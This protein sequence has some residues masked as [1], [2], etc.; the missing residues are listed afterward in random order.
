[1]AKKKPIV[2]K[3]GQWKY[4]GRDTIIPTNNGRITMKPDPKTGKPLTQPI[5]GID[6]TGFGQMMFPG[7]DYQFPGNTIYETPMAKFQNGGAMKRVKI[8]SL[9]KAQYGRGSGG[10]GG[11][12]GPASFQDSLDVANSA[13]QVIDWYNSQGYY[14]GSKVGD[15]EP[16]RSRNGVRMIGMDKI[17]KAADKSTTPTTLHVGGRQTII[18]SDDLGQ[19]GLAIDLPK[20]DVEIPSLSLGEAG[21]MALAGGLN[22]IGGVQ[23]LTNESLAEWE[24]AYRFRQ[25]ADDHKKILN[26]DAPKALYDIRID[27]RSTFSLQGTAPGYFSGNADIVDMPIY[28]KFYT[29]PWSILSPE[30][31]R[32]RLE[33]GILDGTP[34][35]DW[36]DPRLIQ[37]YPDIAMAHGGRRAEGYDKQTISNAA[38]SGYAATQEGAALYEKNKWGKNPMV[39]DAQTIA[40]AAKSGYPATQSGAAEY[41]QNKWAKKPK[42]RSNS[43]SGNGVYEAIN[44]VKKEPNANTDIGYYMRT[45]LGL[46]KKQSSYSERKKLA[47]K[48][49]IKD[50]SGTGKQN[51]ELLNKIKSESNPRETVINLLSGKTTDVIS[52]TGTSSGATT[53]TSNSK[54]QVGQEDNKSNTGKKSEQTVQSG[55]RENYS[56]HETGNGG[57]AAY[58][59]RT[60][61]DENGEVVHG[62]S[63]NMGVVLT[64]DYLTPDQQKEF[65]SIAGG[66]ARVDFNPNARMWHDLRQPLDIIEE[67]RGTRKKALEMQKRN[68]DEVNAEKAAYE[69]YQQQQRDQEKARQKKIQEEIEAEKKAGGYAYGGAVDPERPWKDKYKSQDGNYLYKSVGTNGMQD[70]ANS[71]VRRTLKGF[72]TGAPKPTKASDTKYIP[73]KFQDGGN[74]PITTKTGEPFFDWDKYRK[75]TNF[76]K[77]QLPLEEQDAYFRNYKLNE[78]SFDYL[79]DHLDDPDSSAFAMDKIPSMSQV[80]AELGPSPDI[81]YSY[82]G[83]VPYLGRY[84]PYGLY[85]GLGFTGDLPEARIPSGVRHSQNYIDWNSYDPELRYDYFQNRDK[86]NDFYRD[87]YTKRAALPQFTE[88]ANRRLAGLP[89]VD[90]QP[91]GSQE[92]YDKDHPGSG[93]V[94]VHS[95]A[96]NVLPVRNSIYIPP[97]GFKNPS[98]MAHEESHYLDFNHPQNPAGML[99][100][101]YNEQDAVL[102]SI[103]PQEYK[104]PSPEG[105]D[106]VYK[107]SS[108]YL[109]FA[110]TE[111]MEPTNTLGSLF[112]QRKKLTDYYYNPSEI[113]ARLNEWRMQHN[114]DPVKDYTNEEIQRIIDADV[115]NNEGTSFDLYKLIRG[116]GDLLKKIHDSQVSTGNKKD[117]Y[118]IPMGKKGGELPKAQY[119][120]PDWRNILDYKNAA[121]PVKQNLVGDVRKVARPTAVAESTNRNVTHQIPTNTKELKAEADAQAAYDAL[122]EAMKRRDTLTADTRSD[123]EKFARQAWTAISY[124][125]ATISAVNRGHDIPMGSLGMYSPYEGYDVGGPMNFLVDAVA[126]T[127]GFIV[128]AASR[129]GEQLVDDPLKYAYTMSPLGMLDPETQGQALS[130]TLDLSAVI[131]AARMTVGPLVKNTNNFLNAQPFL[132]DIWKNNPW[133]FQKNPEAYYH[134][135]PNPANIINTEKGVLQG[136][137]QS[138]EGMAYNELAIPGKGPGFVTDKGVQTGLNLRKAAHSENYFSKGVPLDWG[139]YN[140]GGSGYAGPYIAEVTGVPFVAKANGKFTKILDPVT[141]KW[142][143]GVYP[144]SFEG[145]YAVPKGPVPLGNTK[146]YKE[147]WLWGYKQIGTPKSLPNKHLPLIGSGLNNFTEQKKQGGEVKRVK[148]NALPNNWKS[149]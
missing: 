59:Y 105:N 3:E 141:G 33:Y 103:I 61:Y 129:Q 35:K 132:K 118:A 21:A 92:E 80:D 117:P 123:A 91:Y 98:V 27:P 46:D 112:G 119:G 31:K 37:N 9:P 22:L 29:A 13:Q 101:A 114:I 48:Y 71:S 66:T 147:D 88:V 82:D 116:R 49:G 87:W 74:S 53:S 126:G 39:Y 55:A 136:F 106:A 149:Q 43:T 75:L 1:M 122:P 42:T 45:E 50:Y 52:N 19:S 72:I 68:V 134:R 24:N 12:G 83:E 121:P 2:S 28:E 144:P 69:Q 115:K 47:E 128:N 62:K 124:P 104:Q 93:G 78:K 70:Y 60:V 84:N 25:Y 125:M 57:G 63:G 100:P 20:F 5:Y 109:P 58:L 65:D 23:N 142:T 11:P 34:F 32:K 56:L 130:N 148:I 40:N 143:R 139:R 85:P 108:V 140:P 79:F 120:P 97:N 38:K 73:V 127:P 137:G 86:V 7:I 102:D 95:P 107:S 8:H 4:P 135:T 81:Q 76:Q 18:G 110:N 14:G 41:D 133:R 90:F 96:V 113:R 17:K 145:G 146:F 89:N 77:D 10:P 6:E 26:T 99:S 51:I 64:E 94:Y 54:E 67:Q 15:K 131:P 138:P 36:N 44:I 16:A 111:D 30:D